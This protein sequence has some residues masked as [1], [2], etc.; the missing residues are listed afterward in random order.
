MIY[1][2]VIGFHVVVSITLVVVV[3]LQT[4]KGVGLSGV[5]GGGGAASES[6]FGGRG[7]GDFLAKAT[8]GAAII[9]ML[10]CLVLA[11]ISAVDRGES[12]MEEATTEEKA[13]KP[14]KGPKR[15][16]KEALPETPAEEPADAPAGTE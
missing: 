6:F 13:K 2:I 11:K 8:T 4:G 16:I 7:A 1:W 3:L 10:T 15:S 14:T 5:F 12:V 9:F